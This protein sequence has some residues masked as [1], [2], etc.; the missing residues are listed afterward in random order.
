MKLHVR[1]FNKYLIIALTFLMVNTVH[2]SYQEALDKVLALQTLT[3]APIATLKSG[4]AVYIQA[5]ELKPIFYDA[6]LYQGKPTKV[7][8]WLGLPKG[9]SASNKVPA[10]VLVH[11]GGGTAWKEWV[12]KWNARGFAAISI[13]TE[14]QTDDLLTQ[15]E[16]TG[17]W[18]WQ[19]HDW[20]GPRRP[21]IYNDTNKKSLEDQWMYHAVADT[22]LA[23]SLLR[24]LPQIDTNNIGLMGVSWGG[25]ITSTVIGIDQRFAFAIPV[26]GCG[27]LSKADNKYGKA[28]GNNELYKNVWDPKLRLHRAELPTLWLSW[29]GEQHFPLDKQA[30]SYHKVT[31]K[32]MVSLIPKMGHSQ[33]AAMKPED[34]YAFAE[35]IVTQN[36]PWASQTAVTVIGQ[37]VSVTFTSSKNLDSAMLVSSTDNG[38]SGSKKWQQSPAKIIKKDGQWLIKSRLTKGT[39]AWFINAKSGNLTISSHYMEQ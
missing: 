13:A 3:E 37:D 24:S 27:D 6:L 14:G 34:S 30:V 39:T 29:P 20:P 1:L 35:S 25:V 32:H 33:K 9:A 36:K 28:L 12:E 5:G 21:G 2:A 10:M 8:A 7:Y 17:R 22:V 18:R 4:Q 38:V 11:G 15:K 26:Y 23:H 19:A 16:K 31:G